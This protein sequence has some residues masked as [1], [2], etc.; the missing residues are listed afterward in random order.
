MKRTTLYLVAAS[1]LFLGNVK[2]ATACCYMPWLDPLA[3]MGF[4]GCGPNPWLNP[5]GGQCGYGGGYAANYGYA[6]P[7]YASYYT[8]SYP[9]INYQAA[10]PTSDC[11]CQSAA[12]PQLQLSA[13]QVPVTTYKAVTQ[14]VPQT[15]YR[16]QY[17]YQQPQVA[18][19]QPSPPVAYGYSGTSTAYGYGTTA[20][21]YT[22]GST[23]IPTNVP[24]STAYNVAPATTYN[25]APTN[26]Y[27]SY[28]ANPVPTQPTQSYPIPT[29]PTAPN[30]YQPRTFQAPMGDVAGDHEVNPQ[31][32][33]V[34]VIPNS[35]SGRIPVRRATYS[36]APRTTRSFSSSVR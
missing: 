28:D 36:A 32:A 26:G 23:S 5:C 6:Q 31:S 30:L 14:Y 27:T 18:Y 3:W 13:Y 12:A 17:R 1:F 15:T 25:S 20:P 33:S 16:T 4:Y 22:Y 35:Y 29:A 34:P 2:Q 11:G 8:P 10:A 21:S 24:Q 19:S 7:S 9:A